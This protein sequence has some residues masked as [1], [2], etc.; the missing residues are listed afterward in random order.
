MGNTLSCEKYTLLWEIHS[1]VR[2]TLS[3][4]KYTL[5]WE[6]ADMVGTFGM[7]L[8]CVA[9]HK[10]AVA[11]LKILLFAKELLKSGGHIVFLATEWPESKIFKIA[12]PNLWNAKFQVPS[13]LLL[14]DQMNVHLL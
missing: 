13:M 11:I 6:T 14:A 10:F 2:N 8:P 9:F 3:C 7:H 4:E 5:L 1:L 12:T